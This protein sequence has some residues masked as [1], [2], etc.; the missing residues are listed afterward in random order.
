MSSSCSTS[1]TGSPVFAH[2]ERAGRPNKEMKLTSVERFG[3]SL[4]PV[5]GGLTGGED[6]GIGADELGERTI[7]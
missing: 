6:G 5:F 2:A 7:P 3:R 4:S 1:L